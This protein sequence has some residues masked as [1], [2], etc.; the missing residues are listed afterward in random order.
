MLICAQPLS[1]RADMQ[2]VALQDIFAA[3][4]EAGANRAS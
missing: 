2:H 3:N 4:P 1:L